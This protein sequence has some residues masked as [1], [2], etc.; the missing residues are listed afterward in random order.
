MIRIS[1][2][3][4]P[5]KKKRIGAVLIHYFLMTCYYLSGGIFQSLQKNTGKPPLDEINKI[6]VIRLDFL[7]DVT[8]STP[9][10]KAIRRIFPNAHIT[11]L[12]AGLSKN[13]VEIM[14][15]FDDVL[16]FDVPWMVKNREKKVQ[17]LCAVIRELRTAK[18][19]MAIDLSGDFRH[20]ILMFLSNVRYR[21][22]FDITG[23]D[24]LLTHIIPCSSNHHNVNLC[25]DLITY[26]NPE[27][28][29]EYLPSLQI[30]DH[31]RAKASEIIK[32]LNTCNRKNNSGPIVIIH[33]GAS[34]YGRRWKNERFALV[35]D[36]V[37]AEHNARLIIAGSRS[38]R[39]IAEEIA[40]NMKH[41]AM[42]TAGETSVREFIGLLEQSVIFLG[43]DSGPT[44]M[45][46]ATKAKIVALFGPAHPDAVGPWG[47]DHIVLSHQEDFPCSP[48]NQTVCKKSGNSCMEAIQVD[49]V[50]DAVSK[51]IEKS[52]KA[53]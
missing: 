34:W 43:L 30:T 12:A 33:P 52:L 22:G 7:G 10:F 2:H 44:H 38:D 19:D 26:L 5:T 1:P 40:D 46:S 36:R 50:F 21:L 24:F 18:Y 14:P 20:N 53:E 42:I 23:C 45:A 4:I 39:E 3:R 28:K 11:L 16:Y 13:L 37:I 25:L 49:E 27:N 41:S 8:M 35:A 51:Q 47:N 32:Q 9:G 6:L 31:D 29:E 17:R 48:C 15:F